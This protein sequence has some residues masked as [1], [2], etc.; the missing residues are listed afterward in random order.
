M[1]EKQTPKKGKK[2]PKVKR[3]PAKGN[4]GAKAK[5]PAKKKR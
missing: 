1:L 3:K 5:V 2:A 4:K